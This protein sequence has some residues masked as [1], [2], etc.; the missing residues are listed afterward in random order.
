MRCLDRIT[1]T[2]NADNR[3][4]LQRI[5]TSE[6][7][8]TPVN[9]R[10]DDDRS[11]SIISSRSDAET[12]IRWVT[13]PSRNRTP[14]SHEALR[15]ET[16]KQSIGVNEAAYASTTPLVVRFDE[17]QIRSNEVEASKRT[18]RM[19]DIDM[20]SN[21][22]TPNTDD[23]PYIRFAIDQL[24][25]DQD[26]RAAERPDTETSSDSYPVERIIPDYG[27]GYVSH[28]R[29]ELAL[30]RKYRSSPGEG[31]LFNFNAT[32]PLSYHSNPPQANR[33]YKHISSSDSEIF[34]PVEPP[35]RSTRYPDLT[36]IPTILRPFSMITL[37]LLCLLMIT[38][39]M[40]CAIYSA[41]HNGL[42]AWSGG[43]YGGRYFTFG[44]LPQIIAACLF[45]YIQAVMAAITRIMPY[46][47]MAMDNAEGRTDALFVE[48]FPRSL[49][50]P[51]RWEGLK[52]IDVA[53][54]FFWLSIFTIPLQSCLFSVIQVDGEWRWTA[55]Q[56]IAWTLAAI[57]I[58]I[59]LAA[60]IVVLFFHNRMTGLMWDPTSLADM[61]ALLPRSNCLRD[62]PGTDIMRNKDD[63][64]TKLALRS[65]R[66]GYWRTPKRTQG[67]F[68]CL[69][70]EGAS[71]RQYTL[72]G[73]K[74]QEKAS[75]PNMY[76]VS[77]VENLADLHSPKTRFRHIPWYLRETFVIFWSVAAFILL[78]ALI[79]ACFLPSTAIR[80]G[81]P[82]LVPSLPNAAGYSPANFLYSF[83][84]SLLGLLL[85]LFF[86]P[87]DMGLRKLQPVRIIRSLFSHPLIW[88]A[89]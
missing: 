89:H 86:Q 40:F 37:S 68:Y 9:V 16:T 19:D 81:F 22:P 59:L 47:M 26:I 11:P 20:D 79:I 60:V 82:P 27:L 53:N 69:G 13:P 31:R 78:L 77:D 48:L 88:R 14:E 30:A 25:R 8:V 65:D 3:P 85:Y 4:Q 41:Y 12:V 44:F 63:I 5:N 42:V 21:P 49:L 24:T 71:I 15:P 73:G 80:N 61:I 70:E 74:I 32:R 84:P 34:I 2:S 39:L 18:E 62:Y 36:F 76:I 23:T 66:L 33:P 45:L 56:G 64:R 10:F 43:I 50:L 35:Y 17:E 28:T 57:Y 52:S 75:G 1:L 46:T 72:E 87:L 38:A 83:I 6:L 7:P 54:L 55:V 67:I 58:L 51:P 29:E